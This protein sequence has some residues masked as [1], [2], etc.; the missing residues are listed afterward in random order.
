LAKPS[1]RDEV[2]DL[3]TDWVMGLLTLIGPGLDEQ[4]SAVARRITKA[5]CLSFYDLMK[6]GFEPLGA[7]EESVGSFVS[8]AKFFE[9]PESAGIVFPGAK[10]PD[11][12]SQILSS[13]MR[14]EHARR[15]NERSPI[16][17]VLSSG[18]GDAAVRMRERPLYLKDYFLYEP[19]DP[20]LDI[21]LE[22]S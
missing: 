9:D 15:E 3:L 5:A 6:D 18:G 7:I 12:A 11:T 2:L 8:L 1:F 16:S 20:Q 10:P 19:G 21:N 14:E 13:A 22:M 4:R 17:I